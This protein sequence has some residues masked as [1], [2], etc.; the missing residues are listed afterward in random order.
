MRH[1]LRW[2]GRLDSA[3]LSA[4][5]GER[6]EVPARYTLPRMAV[7]ARHRRIDALTV[8]ADADPARTVAGQVARWDDRAARFFA[9]W[10][11]LEGLVA[12]A[13]HGGNVYLLLDLQFGCV[14]VELLQ[15]DRA[16]DGGR[17][18]VVLYLAP[19][20]STAW[21]PPRRPTRTPCSA[22]RSGTTGPA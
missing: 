7:F 8:P 13:G 5:Q 4:V 1:S 10:D 12:P 3:V 15:E 9:R 14:F 16:G 2:S 19:S 6:A 11:E 18:R 20:T 21:T 22:R 17:V